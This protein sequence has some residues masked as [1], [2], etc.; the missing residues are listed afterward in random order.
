MRKALWLLLAKK[1]SENANVTEQTQ[2]L[3]CKFK[4]INNAVE[5]QELKQLPVTLFKSLYMSFLILSKK[6]SD[7]SDLNSHLNTLFH[8]TVCIS[9]NTHQLKTALT[10][11]TTK[12]N[13]SIEHTTIIKKPHYED[14]IKETPENNLLKLIIKIVNKLTIKCVRKTH[15]T[16]LLKEVNQKIRFDSATQTVSDLQHVVSNS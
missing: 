9:E 8:N 6:L 4:A 12:I 15:V 3:M 16:E 5:T 13:Q 14:H 11:L 7:Q 10:V 2:H 1:D